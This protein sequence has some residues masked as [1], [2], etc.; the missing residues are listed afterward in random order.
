MLSKCSSSLETELIEELENSVQSLGLQLEPLSAF[1]RE[2]NVSSIGSWIWSAEHQAYYRYMMG[3]E[4][5]LCFMRLFCL[6]KL[7][8]EASIFRHHTLGNC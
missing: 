7:A 6:N 8:A 3:P 5:E 4:G 2:R 1:A